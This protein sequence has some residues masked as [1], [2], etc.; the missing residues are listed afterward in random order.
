VP[1]GR[2]GLCRDRLETKEIFHGGITPES[3][4]AVI[5]VFRWL[6]TLFTRDTYH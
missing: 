1:P 2:A 3:Q 4:L 6:Q 5:P